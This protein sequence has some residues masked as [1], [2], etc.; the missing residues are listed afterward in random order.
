MQTVELR[1]GLKI[2][3]LEEIALR[4]GFIDIVQYRDLANATAGSEYGAYLFR[5]ADELSG[6][7]P[8][9]RL[10]RTAGY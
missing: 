6:K 1:Q 5:I 10:E 2:A 7:G 8:S 3:C 4:M 9:S